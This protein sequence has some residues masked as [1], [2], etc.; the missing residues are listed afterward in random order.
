MRALMLDPAVVLMDEPL[1]ALDPL[2]RFDL[3]NELRAIFRRLEKTVVLVTLD[4]ANGV[5]VE[6]ISLA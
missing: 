4:P 1:G 6:P 2:I 3:Q 5:T